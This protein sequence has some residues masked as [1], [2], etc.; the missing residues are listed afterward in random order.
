MANLLDVLSSSGPISLDE[1]NMRSSE[2]PAE[3]IQ[4]IEELRKRGVVTVTGPKADEL[5]SLTSEEVEHSSET[6]VELSRNS[7]RRSFA[8]TNIA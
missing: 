7:L 4:K 2:T 6:V 5:A 8:G 1:L 3:L